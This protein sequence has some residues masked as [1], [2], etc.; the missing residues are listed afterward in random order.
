MER[1]LARIPRSVDRRDI[2]GDSDAAFIGAI[3]EDASD[4]VDRRFREKAA[5]DEIAL[6][7]DEAREQFEVRREL[8]QRRLQG[9][10]GPQREYYSPE[11]GIVSIEDDEEDERRELLRRAGV[12]QGVEEILSFGGSY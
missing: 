2:Q 12:G 5:L 7:R 6:R 4:I 9:L 11:T 1:L 10:R 3:E 8:E